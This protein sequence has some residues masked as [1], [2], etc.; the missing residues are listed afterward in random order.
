M[1]AT[2]MMDKPDQLKW[3]RGRGWCLSALG[4]PEFHTQDGWR[5]CTPSTIRVRELS[6]GYVSSPEGICLTH[7]V[8][9]ALFVCLLFWELPDVVLVFEVMAFTCGMLWNHESPSHRDTRGFRRVQGRWQLMSHREGIFPLTPSKIPLMGTTGLVVQVSLMTQDPLPALIRDHH[10]FP[11]KW[12]IINEEI[13]IMIPRV[14]TSLNWGWGKWG[15]SSYNFIWLQKGIQGHWKSI[16][17][18]VSL[19]IVDNTSHY[20][21][22]WVL[23]N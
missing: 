4:F 15:W 6:R 14:R 2:F 17:R 12:L 7:D 11:W 13:H 1:G 8:S 5:G 16:V 21:L 19:I 9:L 22:T 10:T 23:W 20:F 18:A 3:W